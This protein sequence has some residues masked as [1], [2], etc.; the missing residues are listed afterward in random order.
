MLKRRNV[1]NTGFV[2]GFICKANIKSERPP[3]KAKMG[4]S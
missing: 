2:T 1:K 4:N 3:N